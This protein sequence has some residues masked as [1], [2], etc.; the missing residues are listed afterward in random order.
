[1]KIDAKRTEL[2][3]SVAFKDT[4]T[5]EALLQKT[6]AEVCEFLNKQGYDFSENE[7]LEFG[8]CLK[9][10]AYV[11]R[12]DE[13]STKELEEVSGGKGGRDAAM[14]LGGVATGLAFGLMI[15]CCW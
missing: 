1:M 11:Q 7:V 4:N 6:P 3:V 12:K 2:F 15:G 8:Q 9:Q 14:F 10:Y 13:F 5:A